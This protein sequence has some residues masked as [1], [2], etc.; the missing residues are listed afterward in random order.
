MVQSDFSVQTNKTKMFLHT[1][2]IKL[3][4][5]HFVLF[6]FWAF[7]S[8]NQ[9]KFNISLLWAEIT[10]F[11]Y[12]GIEG[13]KFLQI[14]VYNDRTASMRKDFCWLVRVSLF[15]DFGFEIWGKGDGDTLAILW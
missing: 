8:K 9:L 15:I 1:S 12:Y 3:F 5:D 11:V 2:I 7:K 6:L 4:T 13:G 14:L 10:I